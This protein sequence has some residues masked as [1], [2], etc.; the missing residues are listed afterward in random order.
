MKHTNRLVWAG[1]LV[2]VLSGP[3]L[4]QSGGGA[5]GGSGGGSSGG[6]TG[7]A[8]STSMGGHGAATAS[9]TEQGMPA[10]DAMG[11][12]HTGTA[13]TT[14]H[15]QSKAMSGKGKGAA[16]SAAGTSDKGTPQ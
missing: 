7:A 4:A 8:G 14:M 1:A 5:G 12:K 6:P 11:M 15:K 10:S 2:L 13:G 16:A 9:P 3:A